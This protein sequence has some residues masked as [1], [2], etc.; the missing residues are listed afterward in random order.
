MCVCY[1]GKGAFDR[2]C[3]CERGEGAGGVKEDIHF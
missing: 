3:F 1:E 2:V